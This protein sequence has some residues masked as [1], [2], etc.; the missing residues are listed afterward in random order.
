MDDIYFSHPSFQKEKKCSILYGV[1]K[2]AILKNKRSTV[3]VQEKV[4]GGV[5]LLH[6]KSLLRQE[7]FC[8]LHLHH[9]LI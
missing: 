2:A 7:M 3:C 1:K 6:D 4:V 9:N 5:I 8:I